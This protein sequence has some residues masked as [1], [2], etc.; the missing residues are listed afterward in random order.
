[1]M[2]VTRNLQEKC[3]VARVMRETKMYSQYFTLKQYGTWEKA[4]EAARK[5]IEDLLPALP[6]KMSSE[7]R[8]TRR[9]HSGEV[10]VY[11]SKGI[12]RK[13]NGREYECPRWV[14]RWVGCR[15][16]GGLSWSI[17]QFD[18][19]GAYVLAVLA[20]RQRSVNRDALLEYFDSILGKKEYNDIL[21]LMENAT[22]RETD[23]KK[24]D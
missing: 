24:E 10:G 4:E 9:N 17:I 8:M 5:W 1:M 22:K 18:E 23:L 15:L 14:A 11:R 21:A 20:R 13:K 16:S 3:V 19:D 2:Y 12:V 6:P 7:G